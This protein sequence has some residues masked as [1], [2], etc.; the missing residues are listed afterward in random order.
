[1]AELRQRS[2]SVDGSYDTI[3]VGT[4][5]GG[6]TAAA[7]LAR[8]GRRVLAIESH[9]RVGGYAH[10]FRRGPYHFDAAVHLIGGCDKGGLI[11]RLLVSLS[12]RQECEMVAANPCYRAVFPEFSLDAPS[13]LPEFSNAYQAAFPNHANG[14]ESFLLEC[15]RLRKLTQRILSGEKADKD[16][17]ETLNRHRRATV[18]DVIHEH[19][20]DTRAEAALTTLWPYLGLPPKRLSFL[21]WSAML[22]SYIEDGAYYC[23]GTFQV[24]ANALADVVRNSGGDIRLKRSVQSIDV[25]TDGVRGVRLDDGEFAAATTV[26][27]N[28]DARQTIDL[29]GAEKLPLRYTRNLSR[30][31]PSLSALVAYIATDLPSESLANTHETFYYETWDHERSFARSETGKPDWF[32]ITVPTLLD[33]SLA[34]SGESLIVFTT[35]LPFDVEADWRAAKERY[36]VLIMEALE[37]KIPNLGSHVKVMEVGTPKTMQRYTHNSYGALYGWAL[38]PAQIGPGRPSATTPIPGLHL[39]GHWTQPGGGIYGVVTSGIL[40]ARAVLGYDTDAELWNSLHRI[41]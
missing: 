40:A 34:P 41:H 29:V 31:Q 24:F 19:F 8:S 32:T 11:D 39:A 12:A 28:A 6:L 36:R 33:P 1:M 14:I 27:S 37:K 21:Y 3:V 2:R 38:T 16:A 18:A 35:L 20:D 26:V 30:L 9:D 4:G 13:G 5:V 7:I 17:L 25:D 22:M 23:K 15:S 10:A